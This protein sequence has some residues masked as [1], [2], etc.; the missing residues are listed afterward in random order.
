LRNS[1]FIPT[2]NESVVW[3]AKDQAWHVYSFNSVK[4]ILK[5][6]DFVANYLGHLSDQEKKGFLKDHD[7]L[8]QDTSKFLKTKQLDF[9]KTINSTVDAFCSLF[10]AEKKSDIATDLILPLCQSLANLLTGIDTELAN[11]H[12]LVELS[13]D[14]F[15]MTN[16][17]DEAKEKGSSA[18]QKFAEF[19][20]KHLRN[21]NKGLHHELGSDGQSNEIL[22]G[23][24][25][26]FII[27]MYVALVSSLPLL[28]ANSIVEI[29]ILSA[30]TK[31]DGKKQNTLNELLRL[32]GPSIFIS[33]VCA[34]ETELHGLKIEKNDNLMLFLA[35]AN[36]D[37]TKFKNAHSFEF[38]R[39]NAPVLS[40]GTGIHSCI[41][42]NIVRSVLGS[43][44]S[45]FSAYN[46]RFKLDLNDVKVGGSNRIKGYSSLPIEW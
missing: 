30:V 38:N 44:V 32:N 2:S 27:Q 16:D 28:L 23:Y 25:P 43:F 11:N 42:A 22:R 41:G 40:F 31:P 24:A 46:D 7:L 3:S 19:L 6:P 13:I 33:R 34:K 37:N 9:D 14:I 5:S 1:T 45:C 35:T 39:K 10:F 29:A 21:T 26:S 18:T 12:K 36:R 17:T 20:H 4:S 8:R 15:D